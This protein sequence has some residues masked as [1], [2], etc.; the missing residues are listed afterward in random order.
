MQ[1]TMKR[2]P[3][4]TMMNSTNVFSIGCGVEIWPKCKIPTH[5]EELLRQTYFPNRVFFIQRESFIKQT[6]NN[7][8]QLVDRIDV[9]IFRNIVGKQCDAIIMD[10][11]TTEQFPY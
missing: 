1:K 5:S 6:K 9:N 7:P 10:I 4:P 8:I 11:N 2:F 3:H